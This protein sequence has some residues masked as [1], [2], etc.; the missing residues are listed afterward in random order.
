MRSRFA[1]LSFHARLTLTI[2][3]SFIGAMMVILV[4]ALIVADNYDVAVVS[5][6]FPPARDPDIAT[7]PV[8]A[9]EPSPP[10]VPDIVNGQDDLLA[11]GAIFTVDQE[12][13]PGQF[14]EL[15]AERLP[16]L[17]QWSL[18]VLLIFA[19]V[20]VAIASWISRRSLGRIAA[21]T[22]LARD[23][24]EHQLGKRLNLAGPDDEIKRLG[25][26]FDGML[27]R[28]ERGF[29][30]QRLFVANASHELRTPLTTARAALEIPLVQG[31]VPDD[32]RPLLEQALN[33]NRRSEDLIESLLL[34]AR[35]QLAPGE[36][37]DVDLPDVVQ[38]A[39]E[40]VEQEARSGAVTIHVNLTPASVHGNPTL[41]AQ[42][43]MNL[44]QNAIR[45]NVRDGEAW[46]SLGAEPG[47]VRLT[48]ENTGRPYPPEAVARLVEPLHRHDATRT[49]G[50]SP[51]GFG[52]GLAIVESVATMHGGELA[53]SAREG[54][55][56]VATLT[57]PD[58][59]ARPGPAD[60]EAD[61][62]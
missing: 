28:L 38:T 36:A 19:V 18:L 55:G 10:D 13:E 44:L 34:L 62:I 17:I 50:P 42:A 46:V 26:T 31:R 16:A 15:P 25:D 1:G 8:I 27:E 47:H 56:L 59:S 7:P 39:L 12:G 40:A 54:G 22:G 3:G 6:S 5:T 60:G 30:N 43:V 35:G 21:I 41:L 52:L 51:S 58:G 24:S 33:A 37:Q 11:P 29:T 48:V 61:A 9:F 2:A 4:V 20:A 45:H 57:L 49:S 23:L 14:I 32:L 53:L